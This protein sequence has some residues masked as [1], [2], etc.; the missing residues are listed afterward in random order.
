M[1][2][3]VAAAGMR[4]IGQ[5]V[6]RKEDPRL[7]TGRGTYIDDVIVPGM[8]FAAF[9]RSPI[10]RGKIVSIDFDEAQALPG[11]VAVLTAANTPLM[12]SAYANP[13]T[14]MPDFPYPA[15]GLLAGDDV[16][17]VGDPVALVIAE[18]RALAEDGAALVN[19]EYV[20]EAPVIGV[21]AAQRMPVVHPGRDTNI[22]NSSADVF[23]DPDSVFASAA[24]VVEDELRNCRQT[25]LPIETRGLIASRNGSGELTINIAC[26]SVHL[27]AMQIAHVLKLPLN[28]VRVIAKDVGGGFGLKVAQLRDEMAVIAAAITLDR[29]VKWIEDRIEN[30]TSAAHSRD[31]RIKVR[32]A[33][34]ADHRLLA[35]D[36][37]HD[38]DFG[39][40]PLSV[41]P[42]GF[43]LSMM[44]PGPYRLQSYRCVSRGWFTN[45]C[46]MGPYRGPWMMEMFGRE[47]LMDIA[48]R[49]MGI[50][51]FELRRKNI[52]G[53]PDLP[54]AMITGPVL[55]DVSPR[56]TF[57]LVAEAIDVEAFRREQAQARA[58]GR[59]LGLG[60][61]TA[62]EP[63]TMAFGVMSSEVAHIRVEITGKVTAATSTLS[64]GHGTATTLAQ[65][66]A[67]R[68]GV[69]IEDVTVFEGDSART[70][71]GAGAGG[72][73]QA[74]AGGGS[75]M[76]AADILQDKIKRIAAHAYNASPETVR[77]HDGIITVDGVEGVRGTL[78]D[79]AQMA[80]ANPD[81]LPAGMELGLESQH[82]YRPPPFVFSN[83]THACIC[84]V[85]IETGI[86][87]IR[88]WIAGGDSGELINPA[89]VEG[90]IS[91]GV[92]QGIAG[93]LFEHMRYDEAGQ[94]L[95][96][97]LK[98]YLVPTAL[99][100]PVIEFRHMCTPSSTPGGYKGVGEGGAMVSP[101][102]LVNAIA[103]ALAPFGGRWMD[104]PLSPDKIVCELL[105]AGPV[106][107]AAA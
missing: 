38:L 41:T 10:A 16:R 18:S 1:D 96:A 86:V 66:I 49:Q 107:Q 57:E 67:D 85:D 61:A 60:V 36:V 84:E 94:P 72:S 82:R 73:R 47:T 11:V 58:E 92:V 100:V 9:V 102:A 43:L 15:T 99:D 35:A 44:F 29:P 71:L 105:S 48:A 40:F 28:E 33:F 8:L 89:I 56:E 37:L 17:F 76:I 79:I 45:T 3:R 52:I 23:G 5:R 80:Y 106:R 46:G 68:L 98:D 74:V 97:T 59:Y 88:R 69:A 24:H 91:G 83:A 63:T 32:L 95:A 81:R 2:D 51:A 25:Q 90:Q 65:I 7:L 14:D 30:L 21:D 12:K 27:A 26:Q 20:S 13:A 6:P 22:V 53:K 62:I 103:D 104:M 4:F 55:E 50:D 64:Q 87:A 34:D 70:G 54:F 75:T 93:V 31:E 42:S 77:I 39:A 19:V 78:A 101:P